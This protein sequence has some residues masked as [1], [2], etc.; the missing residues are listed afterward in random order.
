MTARQLPMPRSRMYVN[1]VRQG[2]AREVAT[3]VARVVRDFEV[4]GLSA[5]NRSRAGG[6]LAAIVVFDGCAAELDIVLEGIAYG[7]ENARL[8]ATQ[9]IRCGLCDRTSGF[10]DCRIQSTRT[11]ERVPK[12]VMGEWA[13]RMRRGEF[14]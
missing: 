10:P 14:G 2:D 1:A 4:P 9:R 3:I 11:S 13:K 7:L 5:E 6:S 8:R 12:W